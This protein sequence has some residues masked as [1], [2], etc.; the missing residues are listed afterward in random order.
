[1][2]THLN[3]LTKEK[4]SL[5]ENTRAMDILKEGHSVAQ[6]EEAMATLREVAM[7]K[8]SSTVIA[9]AVA[10][11]IVEVSTLRARAKKEAITA[12]EEKEAHQDLKVERNSVENLSTTEVVTEDSHQKAEATILKVE[13]TILKVE[14]IRQKEEAT[15]LKKEV[16]EDTT[17]TEEKEADSVL[18]VERDSAE[19]LSTTE[20][21][22]AAEAR[23]DSTREGIHIALMRRMQESQV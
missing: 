13:A 8:E 10:T 20:V 7:V 11:A 4:E 16:K 18:T 9:E 3:I 2:V 19:D 23:V 15:I 21:D 14:I 1:M 5:T 22:L 6:K 17:L 12:T